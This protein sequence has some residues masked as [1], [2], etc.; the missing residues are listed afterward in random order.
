MTTLPSIDIRHGTFPAAQRDT[1][2]E[3]KSALHMGRAGPQET[4][5]AKQPAAVLPRINRPTS[6]DN[7]RHLEEIARA[8][9]RI[10]EHLL[11]RWKIG[12]LIITH[13]RTGLAN[14][15]S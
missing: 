12:Y 13:Q 2:M 10:R 11:R 3:V 7:L 4:P 5:R 14:L 8:G 9:G 1:R 15:R 6:L